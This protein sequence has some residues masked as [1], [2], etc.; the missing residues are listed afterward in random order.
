MRD[1]TCGE[2]HMWQTADRER[3][4]REPPVADVEPRAVHSSPARARSALMAPM[5]TWQAAT[6]PQQMLSRPIALLGSAGPFDPTT[7]GYAGVVGPKKRARRCCAECGWPQCGLGHELD[8]GRRV[9]GYLK[10]SLLVRLGL[11]G[12][13]SWFSKRPGQSLGTIQY[14]FRRWSKNPAEGLFFW[15]YSNPTKLCLL[16]QS[17]MQFVTTY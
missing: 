6:A 3:F 2:P 8:G 13:S 16:F 12:E 5:A 14:M 9:G 7:S 15:T 1:L 17:P 10:P 4:E 11:D